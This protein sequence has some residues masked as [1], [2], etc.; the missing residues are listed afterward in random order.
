MQDAVPSENKCIYFTHCH[1]AG[2]SLGLVSEIEMV[3]ILFG[4]GY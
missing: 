3:E 4:T 1:L 2:Y